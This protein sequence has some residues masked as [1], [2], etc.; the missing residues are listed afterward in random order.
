MISPDNL[1]LV[2]FRH[3][4]RVVLTLLLVGAAA[5]S[6]LAS[7]QSTIAV[8]EYYRSA[9]D[10]YFL[11]GRASEQI[12]VDALP[13]F[14]RTGMT[15]SPAAIS[16]ASGSGRDSVCR[17]R[18]EVAPSNA[19]THFYGLTDDCALIARSNL[20]DFF[21]EGI[22]FSVT[23]RLPDGSCP[24]EAP[25]SVYRA[26]RGQSS[27][28][29]ANHRYFVN[30]ATYDS[31]VRRGWTPEGAVFCANASSDET[32]SAAAAAPTLRIG[33]AL[34]A[35]SQLKNQSAASNTFEAT[36][37]AAPVA[38]SLIGADPT[39]FWGYNTS[40]PGPTIEVYEGDRV[41][42][43]F[44]NR[45]T[46]ASNVHWHGLPAPA[47]EDGSP[48]DTVA[49]GSGRYYEFT[50]PVG[51]AGTYWYHPHVHGTTAEQ[52]FRGLAGAFIVRPRSDA[53][54]VAVREQDLFITDLKLASSG[55]IAPNTHMDK[56]NGR[57]GQY[58]L[59]NGALRPTLDI[60]P[61]E[62]QRW[63]L[64]NATNARYI[65]FAID[66]QRFTQVGTDGGLLVAPVTGL[67]ELMLTPG[68]RAE[69][70]VIGGSAAG[71]TMALR[72]LAYDRGAMGMAAVA[73]ES[74]IGV[75]K[76]SADPPVQT[77]TLPDALR[78]IT[79]LLTTAAVPATIRRFVLSETGG[80]GM[81]TFLINGKSFDMARVDASVRIGAVERWDVEN[82]SA[83]DHPFH[84]HGTQFQVI[85]R[86]TGG[87]AIAEPFIAWR[88]TVNVPPGTVV[89]FLLRQDSLGKRMFHCH[90]L[91]HE[92]QG[93]MGVV[94]VVQ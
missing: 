38:I 21:Y 47:S 55:A 86:L 89:S 70:T 3:Q 20:P 64:F 1:L 41:R 31:A 51:S 62:M 27:T 92:D 54:P 85:S 50:L 68:Q 11:T 48:M 37:T 33:G 16:A 53:I 7:T 61:G 59:V 24:A 34:P 26:L 13:G 90:I 71:T 77:A 45:L 28:A 2:N 57:E 52:V 91:E 43:R 74:V 78:N 60:R 69:I 56:M 9:S 19:S 93:M 79:P 6:A 4:R 84:V 23:K 40:V 39:E 42:I 67:T 81:G 30:R 29:M 76:V 36:L 14:R 44:E 18:I 8:V 82:T 87:R 88:D 25:V 46:Q 94:N 17:Y 83:M 49:A 32:L 58:L 15:F 75:I 72:S 10:Q 22:D 80:M 73:S 5:L 12:A 65:R 35:L 66:G 63:K